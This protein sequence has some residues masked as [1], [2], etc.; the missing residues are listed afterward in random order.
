MTIVY[1]CVSLQKKKNMASLNDFKLLRKICSNFFELV[2]D[3]QKFD[4]ERVNSLNGIDRERFGFYYFILLHVTGIDDFNILTKSICDQDFNNKIYGNLYSDEGIDAVI[5]NE[6]ELEINIFNFKYREKYRL[7]AEQ[8][9]NEAILSGKFLSVLK[10]EKNNLSGP[11]NQ[12]ASNI[13]ERYNSNKE[14]H[15]TFYIVSNES[16][17][18][19]PDDETLKNFSE[20]FDVEIV[21]IGL[22]TISKLVLPK[23]RTINA[24]L[25]ISPEAVMSFSE[26][27]KSSNISY[28]VRMRLSELIR[29]TCDNEELRN[30]YQIE[31]ETKLSEVK[32]DYDVLFDNVRGLLGKSKYNKNIYKTL[33]DEP[34]K[35]F[36]FN[37]GLTLVANDINFTELNFNKR[38]KLEITDFQVLNGGQTLRTIH[39]F[40]QENKKYISDNLSRAEVL[41]RVLR[42]TDNLLKSQIG[43]YTNSQNS[44]KP[45]DLK[46]SN[47][48]QLD[49][50]R[51]LSE[52]GIYYIRK[53]GDIGDVSSRSCDISIG[54]EKLGQ[55]LWASK[56]FPEMASNKKKEIFT[57]KYDEIF[58]SDDLISQNTINLIKYFYDISRRYKTNNKLE[59][60]D[61]KCLYILYIY[62]NLLNADID[63]IINEFENVINEYIIDN[64]LSIAPSRVLI[65]TKFKDT[66]KK[67]FNISLP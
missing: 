3:T 28:I 25:C 58:G 63:I 42:V 27:P 49:L 41:V 52:N 29:I 18:L 33:L 17:E 55:I 2:S 37:N 19:K 34:S 30:N 59:Y 31:D 7:D 51:Y 11:V 38:V 9:K 24:K 53:R 22:D 39:S 13:I 65:Q 57:E 5:I 14:W 35:F 8:S 36:F 1:F 16:K 6:E 48:E 56:G 12:F 46:S 43:E 60:S 10:T 4:I 67:E 23:H 26:S 50:E 40:N 44:I 15:T 21:C 61:Q 64:K 32:E 20:L 54:M 47:K 62:S 45:S 66:I